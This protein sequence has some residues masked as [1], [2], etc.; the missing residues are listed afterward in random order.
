MPSTG[1]ATSG[2]W[3]SVSQ[4]WVQ[5]PGSNSINVMGG[6]GCDLCPRPGQK[7][8]SDSHGAVKARRGLPITQAAQLWRAGGRGRPEQQVPLPQ[9]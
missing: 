1:L 5:L 4:S 7:G 2:H 6:D 8:L 3:V 9:D